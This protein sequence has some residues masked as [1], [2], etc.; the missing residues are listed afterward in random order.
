MSTRLVVYGLLRK[1]ESMAPLLRRA[2][3]EGRVVLEGFAMVDLGS[4][5]GVIRAE[6]SIVGEVYGL[7][8]A[9]L[10]DVLD[11]AEGV[12]ENPP[13]YRRIEVE[14]LG[15]PAWLYVYDRDLSGLRRI[16]SGDWLAR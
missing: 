8:H 1:G 3:W 15:R 16:E 6:G 12:F 9:G 4:Y 13:L 10:I 2:T 11:R 5:P 14:A 7:P